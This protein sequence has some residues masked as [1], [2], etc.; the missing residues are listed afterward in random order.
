MR[1][2][3]CIGLRLP[4]QLRANNQSINT[5]SQVNGKD[6]W[7]Y[8][9]NAKINWHYTGLTNYFGTW[10]YIQNGVLDWNYNGLTYYNGTW[11]YVQNGRINWDYEGIV[12][13]NGKKY[14]VTNA[15]IDWSFTGKYKNY[16]IK[17]GEVK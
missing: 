14:Y 9:D 2:G 15:K 7:Y 17:N 1:Q 13:Y 4:V 5:L 3:W 16:N 12:S 8:V 6:T 11:Y 10:Y